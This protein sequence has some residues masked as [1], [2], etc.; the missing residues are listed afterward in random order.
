MCSTSSPSP[1]DRPVPRLRRQRLGQGEKGGELTGP[2]PTDRGKAGTKYHLLVDATGLVLH[3]L[4]SSAN[5]HDSML[6]ESLLE[7]NPGVRG[8]RH[9]AGRPRR[10]PDELHADQGD[11]YPR[12]RRYLHHRGIK[13]R[14]ARRGIESGNHLGRVRWVVERSISWLLRF[15][16]L[17]LRYDRTQR[18]PRPLL[19]LG[20]VL[21]DLRR[22]VQKKF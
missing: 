11:D 22:L 7:T 15:T 3:T 18:T 4:L 5:T 14:I 21:I 2:N 12:C 1:A 6:F 19:T 20:S 16:R 13:V 17:G 9:R 10:R 8:H